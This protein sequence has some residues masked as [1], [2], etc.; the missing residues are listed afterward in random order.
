MASL[1]EE[2]M[3]RDSFNYKV[4]LICGLLL[5]ASILSKAKHI[6]ITVMTVSS[7]AV[8]NRRGLYE[9]TVSLTM[10]AKGIKRIISFWR[11]PVPTTPT[12]RTKK[13]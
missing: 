11:C 1:Q 2:E 10:V 4:E 7:W 9:Q 13:N 8:L 6:E 5:G 12:P 3:G